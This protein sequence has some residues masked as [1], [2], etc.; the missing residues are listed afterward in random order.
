[1][2]D[3]QI[4]LI[5]GTRDGQK[6]TLPVYQKTLHVPKRISIEEAAKLK[7]S[8]EVH[9]RW[10]DEEYEA[11]SAGIFR[12]VQTVNYKPEENDANDSD[13]QNHC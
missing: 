3:K 1:M 8:D 7:I 6:Y 12:Y 2:S 10:P 4:T 9:W 11:D 13:N 5:G